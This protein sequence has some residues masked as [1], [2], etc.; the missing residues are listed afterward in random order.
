MDGPDCGRSPELVRVRE[1]LFA[2]L[3]DD[4]AWRL[5]DAAFAGA[6]DSERWAAVEEEAQRQRLD[7]TLL[8]L[9]K[10]AL[11]EQPPLP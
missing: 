6:A 5:I 10:Q 7:A 1:T 4:R 8:A 2:D 11:A 3:P 9:L